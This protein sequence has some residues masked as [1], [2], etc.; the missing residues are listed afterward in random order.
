MNALSA[1][2]IEKDDLNY[3][4]VAFLAVFAF[5]VISFKLSGLFFFLTFF[6]IFVTPTFLLLGG[7][8]FSF[9]ERFIFAAFAGFGLLPSVAYYAGLA[10]GSLRLGVAVYLFL[11]VLVMVVFRKRFF[12]PQYHAH[13][14]QDDESRKH[15]SQ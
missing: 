2:R 3:G 7:F 5:F 13:T 4:L 8:G 9:W 12:G 11:C 1:L 10:L 6:V 14:K 15:E